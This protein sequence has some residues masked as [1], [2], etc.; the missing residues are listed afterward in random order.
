MGDPNTLALCDLRHSSAIITTMYS[1]FL[2][3]HQYPHQITSHRLHSIR[4]CHPITPTP[5][6]PRAPSPHQLDTQGSVSPT[7]VTSV[8][9]HLSTLSPQRPSPQYPMPHN[10]FTPAPCDPSARHHNTLP[11]NARQPSTLS[12]QCP[13][14]QYPVAPVPINPVP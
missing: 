6:H 9:R 10:H 7:P 3:G 5:Q 12:P 8:P 2:L 11:L 1:A 4:P 13:S 14:P